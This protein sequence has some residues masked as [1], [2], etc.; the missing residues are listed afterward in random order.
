MERPDRMILPPN[1]FAHNRGVVTAQYAVMPPD[2]ILASRLPG[3]VDT[4]VRIQTAPPMGARFAQI[5]LELAPDGGT[6]ATRDDGLQHLFYLLSGAVEIEIDGEAHRL[7]PHGYAY[8]PAG[9]SYALQASEESRLIWIKKPY[10]AIDL[11]VPAPIVGHRDK[12]ERQRPH[13][14]GRYWQ[15]LLP[16]DDL[17]F[18]M[19]V[20]I[21]GFLPGN[22]FPYVETHI[23]EHGL[24]M[25]EGQGLYL[26]GGDWHEVQPDDFIWMGPY[27]PQHFYCTGWSEAAYLLY[28]D[29]N[30]DVRFE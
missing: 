7:S 8:V 27:C 20:N 25:L 12:I 9:T 18:D 22:Y 2:G 19:N 14:E 16:A 13:T 6:T 1:I 21:L 15:Y 28:K 24:Y 5:L 29:V 26:L 4:T 17:A 3:F 11:P 10:E 23:M 30:R